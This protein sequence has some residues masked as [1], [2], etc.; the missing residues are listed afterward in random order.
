MNKGIKVSI[1]TDD[2]TVSNTTLKQEYETLVK[3]GFKEKDLR[4]F[5]ESS[6][7]ASF[8]DASL[9]KELLELIK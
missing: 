9:K 3:L 5:A 6:I 1:N 7:N 8:A 4:W 2:M